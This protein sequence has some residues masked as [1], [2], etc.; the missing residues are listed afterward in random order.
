MSVKDIGYA[1]YLYFLGLIEIHQKHY[2][3]DLSEGVMSLFGNGFNATNQKEYLS[4]EE[5]Y[6]NF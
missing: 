4:K 3:S 2:H 6:Q 5:K 1:L